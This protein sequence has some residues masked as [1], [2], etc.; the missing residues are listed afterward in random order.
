MRHKVAARWRESLPWLVAHFRH[1]A[2]RESM[3]TL[4]ESSREIAENTLLWLTVG[5]PAVLLGGGAVALLVLFVD[6]G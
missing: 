5:I 1:E 4:I 2:E 6:K 3:R